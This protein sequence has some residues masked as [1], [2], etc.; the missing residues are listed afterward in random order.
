M[1]LVFIIL[2][3]GSLRLLFQNPVVCSQGADMSLSTTSTV[4]PPSSFTFRA[5]RSA[6]SFATAVAIGPSSGG[7]APAVPSE[8]ALPGSPAVL[9]STG[10]VT[11]DSIVDVD[12]GASNS[13]SSP[14]VEKISCTFGRPRSGSCTKRRTSAC[15]SADRKLPWMVET[16]FGGWA[17]MMSMPI[18]RPLGFV[19]STATCWDCEN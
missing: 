5:L 7:V 10:A 18:M 12:A 13:T 3:Y 2:K 8:V 9:C 17:G 1:P 6:F 14:S 15:T 16:P 4:S 19:R 11:S